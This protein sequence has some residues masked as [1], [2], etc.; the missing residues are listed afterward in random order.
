MFY[1]PF[2]KNEV[3]NTN[4]FVGCLTLKSHS[5]LQF[6]GHCFY[7]HHSVT[8]NSLLKDIYCLPRILFFVVILGRP[9]TNCI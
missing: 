6:S 1:N 5:F 4:F 2:G 3:V 7:D 9:Y 8:F